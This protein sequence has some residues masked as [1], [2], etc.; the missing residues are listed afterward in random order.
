VKNYGKKT[1]NHESITKES[2]PVF[3]P[4]MLIE[5]SK[6]YPISIN[7][8]VRL[9]LE[10]S[11]DL[12]KQEIEEI[13]LANSDVLIKLENKTPKRVIVIPGKIINIVL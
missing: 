9:K 6:T 11:L 12:N 8:K 13:V 10:L 1:G 2:Y 7:G 5:S 4:N 3:D